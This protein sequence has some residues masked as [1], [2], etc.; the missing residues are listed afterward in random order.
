MGTAMDTL[1]LMIDPRQLAINRRFTDR[2][3]RECKRLWL[4]QHRRLRPTQCKTP[5]NNK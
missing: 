3:G 4:L 1:T 5:V 2:E